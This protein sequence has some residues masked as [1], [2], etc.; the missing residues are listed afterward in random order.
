MRLMHG[1]FHTH[2]RL[3]H[4]VCAPNTEKVWG[5]KRLFPTFLWV[6]PALRAQLQVKIFPINTVFLIHNFSFRTEAVQEEGDSKSFNR[7][8]YYLLVF[9]GYVFIFLEFVFSYHV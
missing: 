3:E 4:G 7:S 5:Q 6:K 8:F 2:I 1:E 9:L